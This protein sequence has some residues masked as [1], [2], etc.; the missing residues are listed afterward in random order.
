MIQIIL[1]AALY[2]R[3]IG[4]N[5]RLLSHLAPMNLTV[6]ELA[7]TVR[8][9]RGLSSAEA[10]RRLSEIG[11]NAVAEDRGRPIER[12]LRHFWSPVPW[13]LR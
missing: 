5:D 3:S 8:T 2:A 7:G 1:P 6:A 10:Q 9:A 11:P 13:M 12:V 4:G